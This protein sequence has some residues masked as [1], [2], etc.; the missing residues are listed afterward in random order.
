MLPKNFMQTI[1][2]R[3]GRGW[4][5]ARG[6]L[7]RIAR[8]VTLM[9]VAA[10]LAGCGNIEHKPLG[11]AGTTVQTPNDSKP[12][13]IVIF[14]DGTA[15]DEGSDTNI[16]RLHS[17]ITLQDR[18][19][20]A[21][22]YL[23][24]VGTKSDAVGAVTGSG[25][26]ARVIMAYE[27][28]LN[29]Y[30]PEDEVYIFGFSRGAFS[31]RILTTLLNFAGI[32]EE[33][34]RPRRL[35]SHEVAKLVHSATF[36]GFGRGNVDASE[37]RE[38]RVQAR[39]KD[40]APQGV[41][42]EVKLD[43]QGR[44]AV[45]VK[46]LGLWDTVEQLGPPDLPEQLTSRYQK[47]LTG[48]DV[49]EPNKRYGE[50]LCNVEHAYHALSID[51]NRASVF[52]PLLLSAP[53][54][55]AGCAKYENDAASAQAKRAMR[56]GKNR[57]KPGRLQEVWFSGAH[58]DVGGGYLNGTLNGVSLNW[59]LN[60][61]RP[62]DLLPKTQVDVSTGAADVRYVREDI[63]GASHDPRSG[64]GAIYPE[65][66]RDLVEYAVAVQPISEG[67]L[68]GVVPKLCV[69]ESVL[70]R[71]SLMGYK[72]HE[73]GQLELTR[74]ESVNLG[75]DFYKKT[76]WKWLVEGGSE[77]PTKGLPRQIT[78]EKY[79]MCS[80]MVTEAGAKTTP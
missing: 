23:H 32:V 34:S 44:S 14:F 70:K 26:N 29:H 37:G 25:I 55:F 19:D 1:A 48:V 77:K 43:A 67:N 80:F 75:F 17:L 28:V 74:A 18:G 35:T 78:I 61:L 13:K 73:Y 10:A 64:L 16:K 15:N 27:F 57:I 58:A 12:R 45:P 76:S 59:M 53:H 31:A 4:L 47:K 49:G 69:H 54:S 65:L 8:R 79:P 72:E 60:R 24:G 39:L 38:T 36:P 30:R 5:Q 40:L 21:T 66:T 22:L 6:N 63:F 56:D 52:T 42:L 51:D 11:F 2:E 68:D 33:R 62:F 46:V 7:L 3:V 20:I 9:F 71:R 50:R 41:T